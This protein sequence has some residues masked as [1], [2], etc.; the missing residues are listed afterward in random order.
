[1]DAQLIYTRH[2]KSACSLQLAAARFAPKSRSLARP[3]T[4]TNI[5]PNKR[6]VYLCVPKDLSKPTIQTDFL[7]GQ[8][9]QGSKQNARSKRSLKAMHQLKC[10]KLIIGND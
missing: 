1:M 8:F 7:S 9:C 5:S 10:P 4:A 2:T 3:P 6:D